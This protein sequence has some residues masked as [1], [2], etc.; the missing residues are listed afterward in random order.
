[1]TEENNDNEAVD[2]DQESQVESDA[3][4]TANDDDSDDGGAFDAEKAR[5]KIRKINSENRNLRK[6]ATDAEEKAKGADENGKKV[7][8]LEA[9][10]LRLKIAVKHG[11]PE[12]LVKRLTGTTEEEILQDAEELMELFGGKKPP[13]N[14]PREK[15][16]G[17]GDPTGPDSNDVE[18]I[19]DRVFNN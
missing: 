5:E 2:Q 16:R 6:R 14:Q 13:T 3:D 10:N 8:A 7:T 18:K 1:M 4:D 12:S 11:L 9:E 17:G 15:L 19:V